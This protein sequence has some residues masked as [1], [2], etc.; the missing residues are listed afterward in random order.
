MA[1]AEGQPTVAIGVEC[2]MAVKLAL[3]TVAG[4]ST[5]VAVSKPEVVDR[6]D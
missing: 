5:V 2:T 3:G 1:S 6:P 4:T